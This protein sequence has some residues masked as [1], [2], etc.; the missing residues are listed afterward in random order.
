MDFFRLFDILPYQQK[1]FPNKIALAKRHQD[2][3][4]AFSP[5][6]CIAE[7]NQTSIQLQEL[8]IQKG[9]KVAILA[10]IGSP[11]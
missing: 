5:E 2:G 6:Q 7:I 9:D 1:R 3:W 11:E 4:H 8:G 10:R